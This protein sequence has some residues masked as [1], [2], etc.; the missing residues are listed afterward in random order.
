MLNK[1]IRFALQNRVATLIVTGVLLL[2]GCYALLRND[3]DIFPDLNAPTVVVMTEA[4]GLAPEEVEKTVTYPIETA[5]NGASD[6]RRVRSSSAAGFSVVWVEFNWGADIDRARRIVSERLMTISDKM[7]QGVGVPTLG[8]ESSILGEMLII[9]LTSSDSTQT[10]GMELRSIADRVI[11]PRLLSETG[12]SQVSVIGGD[13]AEYQIRLN[14]EKMRAFGVTLNEARE[15]AASLNDNTSGGVVYDYGNEYLIKGQ[16]H[17]SSIKEIAQSPVRSDERGIVTFADIAMVEIGPSSPK[18]GVASVEAK[19]AVLITVTKQPHASTVKLTG[20]IDRLLEDLKTSLP[21]TVN[22]KTDIFRQSDFIDNSISNLQVSLL[23]GAL[24]VIVV[25]FF[26]LM[27]LRTT[28]I[29]LVALPLSVIVTIIILDALNLTINTMS[30]GGIAIAIGSLVDDAIVDV[31]N[32]YRRLRLNR[33]LPEA[34]RKKTIQ[35]VYEASG[36]V[37]RPIL[38]STI[39]IVVSFLP[40]FFLS[41]LEGR[42]LVPLGISFVVAL[43]ASTLVALT[44]TPVLCSFLLAKGNALSTKEMSEPPLTRLMISGYSS[45]LSVVLRHRKLILGAT[46]LLLVISLCLV[47]TLGRSFLPPFNE[48]SLT[49]NVSALPGLSLEQS[50]KIGLEAE[51]IILNTPEIKTVARKTGRAELDEHSLGVNVSEIEAPYELSDRSRNE[52]VRDL[53]ARLNK[54]PGVNIEI[55]QPI[56]HRIDAMLSGAEAQIAIKLFGNDLTQLYRSAT[57]IK[58][59]ISDVDGIVDVTVEQQVGRPQIDIKPRREVMA[60]YGITNADFL[61]FV[62]TAMAGEKV[63]QVYEDGMPYDVVLKA[64]DTE[65][66]SLAAISSMLIDSNQGKIP[67]STVAEVISTD[68]PNTINREN[69]SRRIVVSAN[70]D[71]TD[72]HGAVNSIKGKIAE[73][74]KLPTGYHIEY[75]GQFE[76][77]ESASRTLLIASLCAIV[78]IF[79]ILMHEYKSLSLALIILVNMPLALIGGILILSFTGSDINIPAIIGFI[80]LM[81][82]ATRNGMLLMSRYNMLKEQQVGLTDRIMQ[83]SRDRLTPIIMTALSSALALIPLAVRATEPGNEIQS[84]MALV[85]LG[86]LITSTFLNIFVVPVLYKISETKK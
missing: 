75:S 28:L 9:G 24:F 50:N 29:S 49:I 71:G 69:V 20:K 11:A 57:Q 10:S 63:S 12:V 41:G 45:L 34:E 86:G 37:R 6:V 36:E 53:R 55:G 22:I 54:I 19:P 80:S 16:V 39:I 52:M 81:G 43:V 47:P 58:N 33:L 83:G 77:E 78:V 42:L 68:G 15:A 7:P 21:K 72:L 73:H 14:S 84:P 65:R 5:L 74:V 17:T 27:N 23:E 18:L 59:V 66:N 8:P 4:S 64:D 67:L 38:N 76:S 79:L 51:Q 31:E 32:V 35:V 82:I 3:I 85:I 30:L 46:A 13:V 70:I 26:F 56:S 25:L 48:G 61:S 40:L 2:W 44:V 60:R 62:S 1:I